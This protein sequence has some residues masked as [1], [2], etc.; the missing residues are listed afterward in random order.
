MKGPAFQL[1]FII[2]CPRY[3]ESKGAGDFCP[4]LFMP[5]RE[6]WRAN[7]NRGVWVWGHFSDNGTWSTPAWPFTQLQS[8]F[9][10][11]LALTAIDWQCCRLHAIHASWGKYE[12][13]FCVPTECL[14]VYSYGSCMNVYMYM[15]FSSYGKNPGLNTVKDAGKSWRSPTWSCRLSEM[16]PRLF[17]FFADHCSWDKTTGSGPIMF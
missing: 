16:L 1:Y 17:L 11:L 4:P 5:C 6:S 15:R 2:I 9:S 3:T 13:V 10:F 8:T 12:T 14:G 7:R